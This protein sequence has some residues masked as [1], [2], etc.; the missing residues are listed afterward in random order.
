MNIVELSIHDLVPYENN[1]RNNIEAVEYVANS[2][3]KFGFKVPIVVDTNN[4]IVAGH[5]RYMASKKLGLETVPCIVADDLTEEQIK[6]FRLADNKVS[7]IATW[8]DELLAIELSDIVDIDMGDFGFELDV[9]NDDFEVQEQYERVDLK[10]RYLEVPVSVLN[11]RTKEW[12]DRKKAW[13]AKG[14]D[15]GSGRDEIKKG[16][17]SSVTSSIPNYYYSKRDAEKKAGKKLSNKEFEEKWL[18]YY[19]PQKTMLKQTNDG[20]MVSIFDPV[21][22]ELMYYWFGFDGAK[23][24][25]PFSGGS[26]RGIVAHEL[27]LQ[28]TGIDIR[29]EQVEANINQWNQYIDFEENPMNPPKWIEGNSENIKD[30]AM[31][32]YDMIMSCPPYADLEV[33]SDNQEDISTMKYDDFLQS[34]RKIIK[35]TVDM[36]DEDRFAVFVVGEVRGKKNGGGYYN[37]VSDTIQA[38]IDAGMIYYNEIILVNVMGSI[39]MRLNKQFCSGRKIGKVHQN[40]LVFYKGDVKNIKNIYKG[41]SVKEIEETLEE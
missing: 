5:T 13:V 29:K 37:F 30:L 7:E 16:T 36:L 4:V 23:V 20:Q 27:G 2:I 8:D 9:V 1:P 18:E 39:A 6:A 22:C 40:V 38:F 24:I 31:G 11:T 19:I 17:L 34:Y 33:Y 35:N 14:I 41:I 21:L 3:E 25:D 32:K 12:Q 28:Y 10:S 26:V 15:S